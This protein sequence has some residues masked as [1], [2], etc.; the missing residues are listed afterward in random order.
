MPFANLKVPAD[1]LS[2]KSKKVL[3]DAV[4]GANAPSTARGPAP[5]SSSSST[6]FP[7]AA[8]IW[9]ETSS[10]KCSDEADHKESDAGWSITLLTRAA[11]STVSS[12]ANAA[13]HH[14][15]A[16]SR[17]AAIRRG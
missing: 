11:C 2:T 13:H 14:A 1:T 3:I 7:T 12:P 8:G 16:A 6:K 10:P 15:V 17:S 4:T 5:P 9:A